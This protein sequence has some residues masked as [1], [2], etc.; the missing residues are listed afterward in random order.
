[1]KGDRY[2]LFQGQT[3]FAGSSTSAVG[4]LRGM[5]SSESRQGREQALGRL[6]S[7]QERQKGKRVRGVRRKKGLAFIYDIVPSTQQ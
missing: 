4:S 2:V 3:S 5:I 6:V 7:A 1:M